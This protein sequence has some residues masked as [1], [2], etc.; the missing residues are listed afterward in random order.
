MSLSADQLRARAGKLTASRVRVLMDGSDQDLY[1]LWRE[2]TGDPS[3]EQPDLSGVWAVQLGSLTEE[4]NLNWYEYR[5]GREVIRRGEVVASQERPWAACTLDGWTEEPGNPAGG[6]RRETVIECKHVSG[7][8]PLEKVVARYMPQIHWQ[9]YCTGAWLAVLSVIEG[10]REPR[11]E[12]VPLDRGYLDELLRRA[13][14][15]WR[16]VETLTPPVALPPAEPPKPAT[17]EVDM[18]DNTDWASPAAAWLEHR[19]AAIVF[20]SAERA[21]KELVP[22]DASRVHGHG[23]TVQR[24]RNGAL[25]IGAIK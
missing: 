24:S 14:L 6:D 5:T 11:I 10:A 17:R 1:D 20:R 9:M 21:I 15:L 4:L 8:E 18:T 13:D 12:E 7:F 2:L 25:R 16:C 19:P 22:A 23:I 3:Y